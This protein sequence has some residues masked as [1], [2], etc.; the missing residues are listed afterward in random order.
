[1]YASL[2]NSI[3]V[4][5]YNFLKCYGYVFI[6]EQ[7]IDLKE[8]EKEWLCNHLG[9]ELNIH[10]NNYKQQEPLIEMTKMSRLLMAVDAGTAWKFQ[11]RSLSD[12]DVEGRLYNVRFRFV[13]NKI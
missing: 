11:G 9:H 12:I 3:V 7:V 8:R 13:S 2:V 6:L 10:L 5:F 1:M 4:I